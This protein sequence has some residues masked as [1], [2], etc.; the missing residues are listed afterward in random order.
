MSLA[1]CASDDDAA[2]AAPAS[3][4][5]RAARPANPLAFTAPTLEGWSYDFAE[6]NARRR[7]VVYLVDA[8]APR[9]ARLTAVA[10]RLHTERHAHNLE[11]VGVVVP[12]GYKVLAA[13]RI[14]ARLPSPAEL[15]ALARRHLADAHATFPCVLD[16]DGA[17]VERYV[18]AWGRYRLDAL[19]AFYPFPIKAA[20]PVGRPVFATTG[21]RSAEHG[22]YVRRRVLK[23]FGIEQAADVDPLAGHYPP[24]PDVTLIDSAGGTHRLRDRRGRVVVF[25]VIAQYC[26]RCKE[27]MR[28]LASMLAAYGQATRQAKP[29]LEV[30]TVCT[31]T[32]GEALRKMVAERRYTAPVAADADWAIR[33]AFRYRGATP[34]TF[35]IDRDGRIRFRHRGFT[36]E[37]EPVLHTEI[38]AL[39]G[40][41]TRPML[42][43]GVYNGDEACRVCHESQFADWALTRH[44][45]AWQTLVRLGKQDDP[46]CTRCHVVGQGQRG[47]FYS[48]KRTP[49]LRNVQ[50]ESCHG[51]SGCKAFAGG[52]ARPVTAATCTPCHDAVHS[53]RFDFAAHRSRVLHDRAAELAALPRAEREERLHRLCSGADAQLFDPDT[54]YIG[55]AACGKCHPTE[56]KALEGGVHAHAHERLAKPARDHWSVPRHKRGSVGLRKPDCFRCHVTGYGRPGG[57][58]KAAPAD[59]LRHPL[60]GV[61]CEACHGPGKAH[62]DDPKQPRAIARLGGTCPECN[63]LP[64]CRQCHDDANDPEFD[65]PRALPKAVHPVGKAVA[66]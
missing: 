37:L 55:S 19:P 2:A 14:P 26:P 36:D 33:S 22:G 58:P 39:L 18:K 8:S 56:H 35:V 42:E 7:I 9:A 50:C 59:P 60:A 62:A 25:V 21:S 15:A 3:R 44:A 11:V 23:Q 49:H 17:I 43:P 61:G 10:Q 28:F 27:E 57:F 6:R 31:D 12:P 34:D 47:G 45:C 1:G 4:P 30:L 20:H 51:P 65:Y 53:P 63:V 52:Q 13:T 40:L 41:D 38:R 46:K 5:P 16:R 66:P 64:I 29:W 48:T 24:A 54:P 32:S